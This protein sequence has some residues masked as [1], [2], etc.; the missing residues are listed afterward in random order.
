M[1]RE[2]IPFVGLDEIRPFVFAGKAQFSAV[3]DSR[4]IHFRVYKKR[5][6][7]GGF[8]YMVYI[9][10]DWRDSAW[11]YSGSVEDGIWDPV[12]SRSESGKP[13]L[14]LKK[15]LAD[16]QEPNAMFYHHNICGRCGRDLIDKKSAANGFGPVCW[17]KMQ[18]KA[19]RPNPNV[20][21][22]QHYKTA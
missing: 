21:K 17:K 7:R 12:Q 4:T 10:R 3:R 16:E 6:H 18:T 1:T 19:K 13:L 5:T 15:I 14:W 20:V 11:I 2:M 22:F 9:K 8:F